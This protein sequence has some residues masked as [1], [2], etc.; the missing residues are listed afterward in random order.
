MLIAAQSLH[1][2]SYG[3]FHAASIA[4]VHQHFTGRNQGR[5]QALYSSMSFGA[6]AG[7]QSGGAGHGKT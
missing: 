6:A 5:G 2:A 3:A 1:A 7:V 4:W